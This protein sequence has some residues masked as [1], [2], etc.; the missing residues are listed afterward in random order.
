MITTRSHAFAGESLLRVVEKFEILVH[1][2]CLHRNRKLR[3]KYMGFVI[4][5]NGRCQIVHKIFI[6]SRLNPGLPCPTYRLVPALLQHFLLHKHDLKEPCI[7]A[8]AVRPKISKTRI[9]LRL[10][11]RTFP[12]HLSQCA[13]KAVSPRWRCR[14]RPGPQ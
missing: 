13:R 8:L 9:F 10:D 3:W 4:E 11:P 6:T 5:Q 12:R 1:Q 14:P 2:N 7:F